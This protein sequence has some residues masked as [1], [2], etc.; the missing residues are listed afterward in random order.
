MC[1]ETLLE[2]G[3]AYVFSNLTQFDASQRGEKGLESP[4]D[5]RVP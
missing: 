1:A 4:R 5:K 3:R 2:E